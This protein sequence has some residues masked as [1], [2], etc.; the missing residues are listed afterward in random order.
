MEQD[1]TYDK[2]G[3]RQIV[4]KTRR[5]QERHEIIRAAAVKE[6]RE[7]SASGI[8]IHVNPEQAATRTYNLRTFGERASKGKKLIDTLM[9]HNMTAIQAS[10]LALYR[11]LKVP[12]TLMA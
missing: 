7:L 2:K 5:D 3:Y 11:C 12:A 4:K 6:V 1:T 9:K 10:H 8:F